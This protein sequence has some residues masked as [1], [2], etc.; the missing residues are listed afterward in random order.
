M[1]LN[2]TATEI[3]TDDNGAAVGIKATGAS[4][5]TITINAK[6]VVLTTGGF[7]ANLDMVVE[8]KPE[9]EGLYDHQRTWHPGPGHQDGTG[10]RC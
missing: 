10:H 7:G 9:L 6:A 2:T 1:M 4:G 3:L 5:E 8:Y